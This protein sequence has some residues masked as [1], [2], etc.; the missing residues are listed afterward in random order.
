MSAGIADHAQLDSVVRTQPRRRLHTKSESSPQSD[1]PM[2]EVAQ[3][4]SSIAGGT[5]NQI[6]PDSPFD[7]QKSGGAVRTRTFDYVL[8]SGLAGGLAG[9]AVSA[10][11]IQHE[12]RQSIY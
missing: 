1:P 6:T 11:K 7:T 12:P 9:C 8:R 5:S 4:R 2:S 3:T 10:Y